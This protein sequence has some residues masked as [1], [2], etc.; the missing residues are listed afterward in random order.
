[1]EIYQFECLSDNYGYLIHDAEKGVTACVDTPDFVAIDRA[2]E[3]MGWK[4]D[5]ILNTHHHP[6]HVGAN[7]ALKEKY[8]CTIV[9]PR[10]D[11]A[12]IPG[13]DLAVGDGDVVSVGNYRAT[14][15]DTPGHTR[16]HIVYRFI[17]QTLAFVGDVVFPM[18]CGRLFEGSAE[19]AWK[20]LDLI[21]QWP[22]ETLLYC[23]HEYS[24][25]NAQFA[26][27]IEPEN[28]DLRYRA[29]DVKKRRTNGRFT[30]PSTL[31]LEL[32]TNPFLRPESTKIR[33]QFALQHADNKTVFSEIRR[34]K[35]Q[36]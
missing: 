14:V 6:D 2:L 31:K 5:L 25:V 4:L 18:G 33:M 30:V 13:I 24:E 1:M 23:A 36:F 35:D 10:A 21:R 7:L 19:Q 28:A 8:G 29:E 26:L 11:A 3:S 20:S 34:L 9:G 12:R 15:Y 17:D 32:Q 16:G 27:A 22:E